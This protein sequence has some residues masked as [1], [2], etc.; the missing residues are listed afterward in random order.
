ML[1][2]NYESDSGDRLL[3][4]HT[5]LSC[6]DGSYHTHGDLGMWRNVEIRLFGYCSSLCD[7]LGSDD[8]GDAILPVDLGQGDHIRGCDGSSS[9]DFSTP[10][11]LFSGPKSWIYPSPIVYY[12]AMDRLRRHDL[13]AGNIQAKRWRVLQSQRPYF[14]VEWL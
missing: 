13:S 1:W 3:G 11:Q 4:R 10:E 2:G 9:C 8:L 14:L 12:L 5:A 6:H 7:V